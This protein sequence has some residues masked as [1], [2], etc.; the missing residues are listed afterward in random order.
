MREIKFRGKCVDNG[1]WVY[2]DLL[3]K[4]NELSKHP[5]IVL[6]DGNIIPKSI[7]VIPETVGQYTGLKDKNGTEV[8]E[9]D[10]IDVTSELLTNFGTT[11]TGKYDTTLKLV[12]WD[13]DKWGCEVLKS[14]STVV[15]SKAGILSVSLKYGVIISNIH[16]NPELLEAN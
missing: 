13:N 8:Y 1:E 10:I 3:T 14:N 11:R 9:G 16:D 2:G 5:A 6:F 15:G 4:V 12:I 7:K